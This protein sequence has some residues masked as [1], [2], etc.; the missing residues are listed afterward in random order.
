MKPYP[1]ANTSIYMPIEL[2]IYLIAWILYCIVCVTLYLSDRASFPLRA[3]RDFLFIPWKLITFSIA[4]IGITLVAPYTGDP[5]WDYIDAALMATLTFLTA[6]WAIGTVYLALRG[7]ARGRHILLALGMWMFSASW[8]YDLYLLLRDGV[9]P[10]TWEA[11]IYASSVLYVSAGLFWNLEY[12]A[13][14]GVT[15]SFLETGFPLRPQQ[16]GFTK[17][18]WFGLPFMLLAICC[19]AYFLI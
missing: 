19:I 5:T 6:P 11:N 9:Y 16:T 14:R 7:K 2:S 4:A 10:L 17:I 1:F 12:K 15:F 18:V 3:Y 8:C 13:G